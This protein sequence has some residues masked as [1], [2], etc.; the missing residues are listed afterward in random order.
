MSKKFYASDI[1][2]EQFENIRDLLELS[3]KKTKPRKYD[4]YDVFNAINYVLKKAV[5][6]NY[7][8]VN[9]HH[10]KRFTATL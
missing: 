8:R 7:F 9:I 4:L 6:G 2:P 1:T 3:R 5:S 10:T